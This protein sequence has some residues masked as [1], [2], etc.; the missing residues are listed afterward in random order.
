MITC[1][2]SQR[3]VTFHHWFMPAIDFV[4]GQQD[5]PSQQQSAAGYPFSSSPPFPQGNHSTTYFSLHTV[6]QRPLS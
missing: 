6:I 5:F 3:K 4:T 2:L 1:R